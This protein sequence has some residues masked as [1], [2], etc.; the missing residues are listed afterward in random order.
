MVYYD[1]DDVNEETYNDILWIMI[2]VMIVSIT[3]SLIKSI[4]YTTVV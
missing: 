4:Y 2:T 3:L 1:D